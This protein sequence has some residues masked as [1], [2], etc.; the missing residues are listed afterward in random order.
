[1]TAV[2]K[3]HKPVQLL[4]GRQLL[5]EGTVLTDSVL[6]ELVDSCRQPQFELL[7]VMEYGSIADNLHQICNGPIYDKIFCDRNRTRSLFTLLDQVRL[8]AP[9]LHIMDYFKA[10]DPYTYRHILTVYALAMLLAQDFISDS[11]EL[12]IAAQACSSHDL[13][14]FCIPLSILKKTTVLGQ[15]ERHHLEHHAAAG[16]V[17]LSYFFKDPRHPVAIT[18]RDHH[19]RCNGS[20]YPCGIRLTNRIVEIVAVC[21]VFDALI[22][23][24]PY[25]PNA[26]DL[27]TALEEIT[28]MGDCGAISPDLVKALIN[29]NRQKRAPLH[30]CV[31]SRE[32]RGK[33]PWDNRYRGA[34]C[35]GHRQTEPAIKSDSNPQ[36]ARFRRSSN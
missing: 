1:M 34:S 35:A 13:G 31:I 9:L 27:R 20:G 30:E 16:Y 25:R 22:A 17:L 7:K 24:R 18:A 19:E 23:T 5:A 4:D 10:K 26:Y 15:A 21:D 8:P 28:E 12:M 29:Y 36:R 11:H 2:L 3:L 32:R 6:D 14:K 33:P